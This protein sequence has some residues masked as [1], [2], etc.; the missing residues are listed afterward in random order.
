MMA[1][2]AG[3]G[4]GLWRA[5]RYRIAGWSLAALLLAAPA[6]AMR[7]SDEMNWGAE[8]FALLAAMLLTAGAGIELACR[9]Q[10]LAYR[11]GAGLAVGGTFLMVWISVAV[12][13]LGDGRNDLV[14]VGVLATGLAG[15]V[16]ARF[17]A[18]GMSKAMGAM[19]IAQMGV[20]L[21]ALAVGLAPAGTAIQ[22]ICV[23]AMFAVL[24][25]GAAV[26]FRTAARGA[27]VSEA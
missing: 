24:F 19:A 13:I 7:F 21:F 4:S 10:S 8:D 9:S 3:N 14:Y 5:H 26:F 1:S 12:G 16:L 27:E 22:A 23:N 18:G 2:R 15:A 25:I 11:A 6:A 20:T 17:E